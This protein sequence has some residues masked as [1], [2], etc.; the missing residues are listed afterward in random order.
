[1][2][3]NVLTPTEAYNRVLSS[4]EAIRSGEP[5]TVPMID[6]GDNVRQ[7]DI[8]L[9]RLGARRPAVVGVWEGNQLA[10]GTT[11]GSRHTAVGEGVVLSRV[12][13]ADA[14]SVLNDLVPSTR[15][16]DQ[17]FGPL[18]DAPCGVAV[19]HPEHG[20]KILPAGSYL[21]TH[22]RAFAEEIRRQAD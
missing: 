6:P 4:A 5:E 3:T 10:L 16:H 21:V 18:I 15:G 22:Q 17:F 12:D 14:T 9:I 2:K 19:P 8:Y 20:H 13:E 11:Q 7:G 1:M